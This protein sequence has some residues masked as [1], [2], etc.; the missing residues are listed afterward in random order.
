MLLCKIYTFTSHN[1][2]K[3]TGVSTNAWA[4]SR[5]AMKRPQR[6]PQWAVSTSLH[7][8]HPW[9]PPKNAPTNYAVKAKMTGKWTMAVDDMVFFF[10]DGIIRILLIIMDIILLFNILLH[11]S[12][13]IW[14]I[15]QQLGHS[16]T[17]SKF[18]GLF[19][20]HHGTCTSDLPRCKTF[21][22]RQ[23][24]PEIFSSLLHDVFPWY[25]FWMWWKKQCHKPPILDTWYNPKKM[26]I[27]VRTWGWLMF[28]A[29]GKHHISWKAP[30]FRQF[31]FVFSQGVRFPGTSNDPVGAKKNR[32]KLELLQPPQKKTHFCSRKTETRCFLPGGTLRS[33]P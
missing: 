25:V 26:V 29:L 33:Q 27:N 15:N 30:V 16:L 31:F 28:M 4:R 10:N 11:A 9:L 24:P 13:F 32:S 14:S 20:K 8:C 7:R 2:P 5:V 18:S 22:L 19:F 12:V 23:L 3:I 6:N 17:F 21:S 1:I